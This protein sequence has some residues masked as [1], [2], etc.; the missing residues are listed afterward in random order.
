MSESE[1]DLESD[2]Y[3]IWILFEETRLVDEMLIVTI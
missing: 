1:S 3:L 2:L